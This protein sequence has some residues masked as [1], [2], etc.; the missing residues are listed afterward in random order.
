M[1]VRVETITVGVFESNC[2]ILH[3]AGSNEALVVDPGG[4]AG[5]IIGFLQREKLRVAAYLVTHGHMDHVYALAEVSEEFPAPIG[6]HPHDSVWA[7]T[8][9][10]AMLPWYNTPRPPQNIERHWAEGQNWTDAGLAYSI[11][12]TPGH[13]PGSVSFYF[14]DESLLFSGDVLFAG[15]IGRTDLPGGSAPTLLKSLRRLIALP[16]ET[17]VY[18]G[19]GPATTIAREKKFNPFLRDTSWAGTG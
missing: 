4:D 7:F 15:G 17:R 19:H 8:S 1:P 14:K 3:R 10:N 13:S 11:I 12:E 18:S 16:D 9:V 2:H 6:L 5:T